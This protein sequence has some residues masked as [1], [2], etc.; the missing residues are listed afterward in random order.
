MGLVKFPEKEGWYWLKDKSNYIAFKPVPVEACRV[1]SEA[2]AFLV[3]REVGELIVKCNRFQFG[4]GKND[5]HAINN[6][7]FFGPIDVPDFQRGLII[8]QTIYAISGWNGSGKAEFQNDIALALFDSG[9][10]VEKLSFERTVLDDV[11]K[12]TLNCNYE[13]YEALLEH[14]DEDVYEVFPVKFNY[15]TKLAM[16]VYKNFANKDGGKNKFSID[17][18]RRKLSTYFRSMIHRDVFV[19]RMKDYIE[20][21]KKECIVI[22]DL[23]YKNEYDF[24]HGL[25]PEKYKVVY[26]VLFKRNR[27]PEWV[28][29]GYSPTDPYDMNHIK[30][31]YNTHSI[32]TEW[33][34][35]NQKLDYAVSN[36][37][38]P[39]DLFSKAKYIAEGKTDQKCLFSAF[40]NDK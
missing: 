31:R 37:T 17:S 1:Q 38:T 11:I 5:A 33:C 23:Y 39:E 22:D 29:D 20:N 25:D 35:V 40:K 12:D 36:D 14:R 2:E 8:M 15:I 4:L 6:V 21:S 13:E 27:I 7:T 28:K 9:K 3:Q 34:M 26:I 32:D 19:E 16:K 10:T 18:Y 30:L 24:L